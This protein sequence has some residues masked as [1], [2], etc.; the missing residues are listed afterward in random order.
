MRIGGPGGVVD[1]LR[2]VQHLKV[3]SGTVVQVTHVDL[4]LVA[5]AVEHEVTTEAGA[6]V[7]YDLVGVRVGQRQRRLLAVAA[8]RWP[9]SPVA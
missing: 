7:G 1:R 8:E 3:G 9:P 6:R 5:L 2:Q 4:L